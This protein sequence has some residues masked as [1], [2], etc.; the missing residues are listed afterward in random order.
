VR[1]VWVVRQDWIPNVRVRSQAT[2]EAVVATLSRLTLS[3]RIAAIQTNRAS[4]R[5]S[6]SHLDE[7]GDASAA[8][9]LGDENVSVGVKASVVWM[10]EAAR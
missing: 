10:D 8:D 5:L 9:P 3:T 7:F 2:F 4:R 6:G 1:A